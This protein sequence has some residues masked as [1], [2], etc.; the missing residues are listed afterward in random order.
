MIIIKKAYLLSMADVNYELRD[1]LIDKG[2]ILKISQ[3]INEEDYKERLSN[4]V[5]KADQWNDVLERFLLK[6]R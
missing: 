4:C 3:N 2:K 5:C 1:I 6:K